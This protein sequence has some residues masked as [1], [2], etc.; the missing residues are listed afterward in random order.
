VSQSD[1]FAWLNEFKRI[2][3]PGG[4][5]CVTIL[6]RTAAE[7]NSSVGH[8]KNLFQSLETEGSAHEPYDWISAAKE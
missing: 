2:P 7:K 6:G 5:A 8:L 3:K 1:A 4:V